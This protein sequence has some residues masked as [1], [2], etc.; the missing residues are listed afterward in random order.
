MS[1]EACEDLAKTF[2]REGFKVS[3]FSRSKTIAKRDHPRFVTSRKVLQPGDPKAHQ[4]IGVDDAIAAFPAAIGGRLD[5][6]L[7]N[8]AALSLKPGKMVVIRPH[9]D[10]PIAYAED[11]E[12][13]AFLLE[14]LSNKGLLELS[15]LTDGRGAKLT[16]DGWRRI[17][18][19]TLPST[20]IDPRSV[21]VAMWF[22]AEG[23]DMRERG[24]RTAIEKAG[25]SEPF[26][27]DRVDFLGRIDDRIIAELRKASFVVADMT[28]HR[29]NVYF[30]AGF[31]EGLGKPVIYTCHQDDIEQCHFDTRQ[32]NIVVWT[33]ADDLSERLS[34]R[35]GAVIGP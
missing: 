28:S 11:L 24:I 31:A 27:A 13:G 22:A 23:R 26:I 7:L 30:E 9:L 5:G 32:Q 16:V 25:Y 3:A 14:Q 8:L 1:E 20:P 34:R 21:F 35:I 10:Y 29:P 2:K 4:F 6:A 33:D 15:P 19:L 18:E 12:A 17:E